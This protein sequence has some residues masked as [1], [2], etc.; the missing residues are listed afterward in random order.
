MI[1]LEELW[2]A[3]CDIDE[4]T[5]VHLAFDGEDE[6]DTFKFSERDKWRRYDKS[7]VKYLP[8]FSLMG[9]SLLPEVHLTKL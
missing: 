9:S 2:Y 4:H 1:T 6:F 3:W 5:E 8:L 7:I